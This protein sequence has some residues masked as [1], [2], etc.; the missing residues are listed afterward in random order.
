MN[1]QS[2]NSKQLYPNQLSPYY[3]LPIN[4]QNQNNQN[5]AFPKQKYP[6]G[7]NNRN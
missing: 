7:A 5:I 2:F 4:T 6:S 3:N 1:Y